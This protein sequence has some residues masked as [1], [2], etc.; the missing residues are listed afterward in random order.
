MLS[1][2]RKRNKHSKDLENLK[3]PINTEEIGKVARIIP[4][5]LYGWVLSSSHE[6]DHLND[7]YMVQNTEKGGWFPN[8]FYKASITLKSNEQKINLRY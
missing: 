6:I 3:N 1:Y 4:G 8:S 7:V 5:E 2:I